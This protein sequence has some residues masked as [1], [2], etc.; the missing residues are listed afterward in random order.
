MRMR[1]RER[2]NENERERERIGRE[3]QRQR[4]TL[5]ERI[6]PCLASPNRGR[7]VFSR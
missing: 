5:N 1:E 6:S 3:K 7:G 4:W 2:E